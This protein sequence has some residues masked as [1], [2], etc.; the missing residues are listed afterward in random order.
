MKEKSFILM[1][2]F[3]SIIFFRALAASRQLKPLTTNENDRFLTIHEIPT[4]RKEEDSRFRRKMLEKCQ[5]E[6]DC[7]SHCCNLGKCAEKLDCWERTWS[8]VYGIVGIACILSVTIFICILC[9]RTRKR[10]STEVFEKEVVD[11]K[12]LEYSKEI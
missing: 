6:Y 4:N 11:Q 8:I 3:F 1:L 2:L 7:K 5:D 10:K 9:M 12:G